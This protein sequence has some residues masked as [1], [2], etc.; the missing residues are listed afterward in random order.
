MPVDLPALVVEADAPR[1]PKPLASLGDPSRRVLAAYTD[2][3]AIRLIELPEAALPTALPIDPARG[4]RLLRIEEALRT[5]REPLDL[6]DLTAVPALRTSVATAYV[7]ARAHPED[8]EAPFLVAEALRTLARVED[9][10]GDAFG[11]RALRLR[12]ELIDGGRRIGLSEGGPLE[13][14][15][16]A[17]VRLTVALTDATKDTTLFLDGEARKLGDAFEIVPGEHHLRI[18][19]G[20]RT[21]SAEWLTI[22]EATGLTR[23]G[24]A[25]STPCSATDLG[26]A[27]G[28]VDGTFAV[29][30]ARW[31]HVS[32]LKTAVEIRICSA[33]QCGKASTWSTVP[34]A[35]PPK[36]ASGSSVWSSR[37]TWVGLGAAALVGGAVT[38][39]RLGAF[40]RDEPP[41][42]VWRW[43]GAR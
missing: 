21:L 33:T 34:L 26:A 12:A 30:C 37:W 18:T 40:D 39:W 7:E 4:A 28:S 9:L 17:T 36:V 14:T 16:V 1:A 15:K 3:T 32:R 10:A 41:P 25:K 2:A 22:T 38:A 20:A 24:G 11:A 23:R 27:L 43:E 13:P 42:P 19:S 5:A 35:E 6:G 29:S 31:A 8:P